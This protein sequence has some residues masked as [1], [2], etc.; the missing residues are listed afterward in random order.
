MD[1]LDALPRVACEIAGQHGSSQNHHTVADTG[2]A[3][4][5]DGIQQY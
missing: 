5:K 4:R 3:G 2:I 1:A